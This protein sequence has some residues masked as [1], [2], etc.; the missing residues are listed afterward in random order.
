MGLDGLPAALDPGLSA[1][2]VLVCLAQDGQVQPDTQYAQSW[3][4]WGETE[5]YAGID[6]SPG[7][8]VTISV[9]ATAGNNEGLVTLLNATENTVSG[10]LLFLLQLT[11]SLLVSMSPGVSALCMMS[12]IGSRITARPS[13]LIAALRIGTQ[14]VE[15]PGTRSF[16]RGHTQPC[17]PSCCIH[18][19]TIKPRGAHV[20]RL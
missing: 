2:T 12:T 14:R 5:T 6:V 18:S 19:G 8:L 15:Y 20:L 16:L 7:D 1:G 17:Q 4:Q 3:Y 9:C 11:L 13:S 10:Q